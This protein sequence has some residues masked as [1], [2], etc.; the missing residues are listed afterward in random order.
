M[1]R[2]DQFIGLILLFL[3]STI[4]TLSPVVSFVSHNAI[5]FLKSPNE[6]SLR[7]GWALDG[8]LM[9]LSLAIVGVLV[10]L[11]T[12][13]ILGGGGTVPFV[14]QIASIVNIA[15]CLPSANGSLAVLRD[16]FVGFLAGLRGGAL[17][18]LRDIVGSLLDGLHCEGCGDVVWLL[19]EECG[20]FVMI[21]IVVMM[22][23][24]S[25]S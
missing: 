12:K 18:G 19:C 2:S 20:L 7:N 8:L 5:S 22:E 17:D 6:L 4:V 25:W 9:G 23:E 11:V 24:R 13:S 3:K 14:S 1:K 15:R 10:D 21:V 16:G